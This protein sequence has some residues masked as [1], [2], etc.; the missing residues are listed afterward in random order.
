[1]AGR[2]P[3]CKQPIK[4]SDKLCTLA[5]GHEGTH[6]LRPAKVRV[7]LGD[8]SAR[9]LNKAE[10]AERRPRRSTVQDRGKDQL[11]VDKIV[12]S[13]Y[14]AWLEAGSP[15][16]WDVD[17]G[18]GVAVKVP[19]AAAE[20]VQWRIRKAGTLYDLKIRFGSVITEK[21]Y[22]EVVFV[23]TDKPVVAAE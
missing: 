3:N 11:A 22:S 19:E 12:D 9:R 4:G 23:A 1:M 7:A 20:T 16:A 6:G 17:K 5:A 21:G 18:Y 8:V 14:K 10:M 2:T 13:A 15:E